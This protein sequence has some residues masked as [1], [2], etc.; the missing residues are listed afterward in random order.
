MIRP[1]SL[2]LAA[3]LAAGCQSQPAPR[4]TANQETRASC[5]GSVDRVFDAQNR[6]DLSRRDDRDAA[7]AAGY[8]SGIVTR[9]M[10]SRFH[11]DQMVTDCVQNAGEPGAQARDTGTTPTFSP[12]QR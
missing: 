5:R 12:A 11:R 10:S 6:A 7:F 4:P 1:A 8:V 9:G 2:L 3:S